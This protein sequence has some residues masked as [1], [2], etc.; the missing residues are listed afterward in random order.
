[1]HKTHHTYK[2]KEDDTIQIITERFGVD[3]DV[4]IKYHN[5]HCRLEHII[6]EKIPPY[7]E[8]I[9]L[10]PELWNREYELNQ[11]QELK[12]ETSQNIRTGY[13]RTLLMRSRIKALNYGVILSLFNND[14]VN[15]IKYEVSIRWISKI[16]N[17]YVIDV[18][19][20]SKTYINDKEL[21][22]MAEE[23]AI[24]TASALYPLELIVTPKNEIIGINNFKEIQNRWIKVKEKI[25]DYYENEILEKYL[26]QND[27][28][29][30][31]PDD[32]LLL[33]CLQKNDWFI[34]GFFNKIYQTYVVK[35]PFTNK[36]EA[37]FVFDA[38]GV[39]YTVEQCM[40][41]I[42]ERGRINIE[43]KGIYSDDRSASDLRNRF[44]FPYE[45]PGEKETG[46]YWG[47]YFIEPQFN[48]IEAFMIEADLEKSKKKVRLTVSRI[49]N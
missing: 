7:T 23:L 46:K 36:I 21:D 9:L 37:P 48:T 19:K 11:V 40:D 1:M 41:V 16:A 5:K 45:E 43:M 49:N 8:E 15:T 24:K 4:W 39:E 22:L 2:I 34:H 28:V 47:K 27:L 33:N 32:G 6:R 31:D 10:L 38:K 14:K 17:N 3:K 42:K 25:R 44:N 29:I 26:Q 20:I 18:N 12:T 35:C 30:M 13:E